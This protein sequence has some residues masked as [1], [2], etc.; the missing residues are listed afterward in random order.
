MPELPEVETVC[1]GLAL[2]LEGR[3]LARVVQ[4][5]RDLRFPLPRNF[6]KRLE[7]RIVVR[8]RRRA[9]YMIWELDD[10]QALLGHLGM[11]GRLLVDDR[12]PEA[13][14]AHD[15]LL[16]QTED[17]ACV[18][19]NDARRFGMMDLVSMAAL[20]R[21]KLL[22]GLGPEP[23][24]ETFDAGALGGALKGRKTSIKAALLDQRVVAGLGNIYV[25]EAL[26]RAGI[27]PRRLARTVR[28]ERV[29]RLV[30]AI[31]NV[32]EEAVAAG[33]SSLRDY[34]RT[35]GELGLFQHQWRVYDREGTPCPGCDCDVSRTGG[36]RR[37]TQS[38]RSTFYCPRRQ[39]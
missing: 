39:R 15:H 12:P 1:R 33:G 14:D 16:F 21:H 19:F 22:K 9:K 5:R 2:R 38:G 10:G 29:E 28:N 24:E 4:R 35:D 3:R 11:T 31:K 30:K 26:F 20:S 7:G 25:S 27:S 17:G 34:V 23:L 36:V 37:I 32:L 13:L 18:R 8:I 6:A